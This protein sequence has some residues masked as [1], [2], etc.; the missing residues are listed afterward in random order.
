MNEQ[1]NAKDNQNIVQEGL[2]LPQD[3][4][5]A[6]P[7]TERQLQQT[8]NKIEQRMSKFER[9]TIKLTKLGTFIG[10]VTAFIFGLQ[11]YEMYE[12]GIQADKMLYAAN[13]FA[14][15][16]SGI[17]AEIS[18]AVDK[19]N[20]QAG[21]LDKS[22]GQATR[23]ARATE[24]ANA[25]SLEFDRPWIGIS[26]VPQDFPNGNPPTITAQIMNNGRRTAKITLSEYGSGA[27]PTFPDDIHY[28]TSTTPST[29][30]LVPNSHSDV[31][32]NISTEAVDKDHLSAY[33]S[34]IITFF[35]YA[36]I[37]Y[38]DVIT[39]KKHWTHAC[40]RYIPTNA[41]FKAGFYTCPQYNDV[42]Q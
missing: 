33:D 7:A 3:S 20:L 25:H 24:Q 30:L 19:L 42:D 37:E 23:L 31:I 22:V 27:Y 39:H 8:E 15:S 13:S 36:N 21:A 28:P 17:N 16:A 12:S 41:A 35:V 6:N 10:F 34:G 18:A 4:S 5:P 11:L 9:T 26:L 2:P 29:T 14:N 40:L 32:I 38:E 1:D